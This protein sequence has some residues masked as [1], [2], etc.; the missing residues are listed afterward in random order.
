M[1]CC[2]KLGVKDKPYQVCIF[3]YYEKLKTF[4][5]GGNIGMDYK[6]IGKPRWFTNVFVIA[7]EIR[8]KKYD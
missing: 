5:K 3:V 2:Y 1:T 7:L 6:L 4:F 8:I